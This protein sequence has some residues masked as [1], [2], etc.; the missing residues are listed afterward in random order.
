MPAESFVGNWTFI[1]R[2]NICETPPNAKPPL[3][4]V[5]AAKRAFRHLREWI[6]HWITVPPI[7]LSLEKFVKTWKLLLRIEFCVGGAVIQC[8]TDLVNIGTI[9]SP[10]SRKRSG[11]YELKN[12][13]IFSRKCCT[14]KRFDYFCVGRKGRKCNWPSR[15]RNWAACKLNKTAKTVSRLRNKL[16][17]NKNETGILNFTLELTRNYNPKKKFNPK[18]L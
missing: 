13:S 16:L 18:I 3:R 2:L 7:C 10:D 17:Q 4:Y 5:Q 9:N 8:L 6:R 15:R 12:A 14:L 1:A 11:E